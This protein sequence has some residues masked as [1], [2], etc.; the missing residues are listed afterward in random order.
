MSW[1]AFANLG[2]PFLAPEICVRVTFAPLQ[3]PHPQMDK[4]TYPQ[5]GS[6]QGLALMPLI[7]L[8]RENRHLQTESGES[9]TRLHVIGLDFP[10][11]VL[12]LATHRRLE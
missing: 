1:S 11:I 8:L 12:R 3:S 5:I 6:Q 4:A 9:G 10:Q 7:S 2:L